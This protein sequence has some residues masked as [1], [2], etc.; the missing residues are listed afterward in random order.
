MTGLV[1]DSITTEDG[2]MLAAHVARPQGAGRRPGLVLCHSF[3]VAPRGAIAS[4]L[5]FPELADRIASDEG[6][7]VLTFDFRGSG[8]SQGDF[9][10]DGWLADQRAAVA[11]L[12]SRPEVLGVWIAGFGVGGSLGICTAAEDEQVRGVAAAGSQSTLRDW[13]RDSARFLAHAR[14]LG[15]LRT[16]GFPPDVVAWMRRV[17]ELD[18]LAAARALAPRP[19]LV[20][21]GS[22]DTVV[23]VDHGRALAEAHGSAELR[24]VQNAGHRLRHDPRAVASL[25]GWLARQVP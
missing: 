11:A 18:P 17:A 10:I 12:R 25:L 4:G 13:A 20:L 6:W 2:V 3:P 15:L 24:I 7:E 8:G 23:P 5:T 9:S 19:L 22:A 21:H 14:S 1:D 16:P